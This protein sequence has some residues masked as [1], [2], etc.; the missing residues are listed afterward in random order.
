M[1]RL[2]VL[3]VLSLATLSVSAQ[4]ATSYKDLKESYDYHLYVKDQDDPYNVAWTGLA[5]FAIPGISQLIM[6]E[7]R[8]WY[9][10]GASLILSS[11]CED[12]LE[13]LQ[14]L[15]VIDS[16]GQ[17]SFSDEDKAKKHIGLL[18]L[19]GLAEL[20][21]MIWSSVDASHIAKVKNMYY[22]R[23]NRASVDMSLYPSMDFVQTG[24]GL[25]PAAGMTLALR[26]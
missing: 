15:I 10:L 9:F 7:N 19:A 14:D 26:F 5:S 25:Q 3:L 13:S 12:E 18:C 1:K 2:I 6:R 11:I 22:Q 16:S 23:R 8:G 17:G 24:N 4:R 21:V 20:G